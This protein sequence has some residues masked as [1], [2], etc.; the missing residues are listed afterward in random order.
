MWTIKEAT[1]VKRQL[2]VD[3][4]N[5]KITRD[6]IVV[7]KK[8]YEDMERLGPE[9]LMKMGKYDDHHLDGDWQGY[10]SACFSPQGRII[11]TV[12]EDLILVE[13]IRITPDHDYT[14]RSK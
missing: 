3:F 10:R 12:Q 13:V 9:A 4:G 6:D 8:W 14:R 1:S 7:I 11:Y 2:K 5:G